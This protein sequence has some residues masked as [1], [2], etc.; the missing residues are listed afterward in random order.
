MIKTGIVMKTEKKHAFIM[1]SQGEFL[2]VGIRKHSPKVGEVFTGETISKNNFFRY[3]ALA[4][5]VLFIV[6]FI[7]FFRLYYTPA[8]AV[9]ISIN[10]S[11]RLETNR[12]SRIIKAEGLNADGVKLLSSTR[13]K[14]MSLNDGLN[15]IVEQAKKDNYITEAYTENKSGEEE[16]ESKKITVYIEKDNG[17]Y[18]VDISGF[19]NKL[20]GNN[21]N[22]EI[23]TGKYEAQ[24]SKNNPS[25]AQKAEPNINDEHSSSSN[26]GKVQKNSSPKKQDEIKQNNFQG[27][28]AGTQDSNEK[29]NM[30]DNKGEKTTKENPGSAREKNS[31]K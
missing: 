14:N 10:P 28:T 23:K 27:V 1:T 12:W 8:A 13:L 3:A 26:T 29:Q 17:K 5:S 11:V 4:A 18:P 30:T 24:S 16:R 6:F 20:Q 9:V 19:K 15:V 21:L 31:S 2:R 7:D 25:N 22:F